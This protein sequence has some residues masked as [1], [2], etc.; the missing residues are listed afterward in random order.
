MPKRTVDYNFTQKVEEQIFSCVIA[1]I[2]IDTVNIAYE[3]N[4]IIEGVLV[5]RYQIPGIDGQLVAV[6]V[7]MTEEKGK[8]HC[9]VALQSEF[10]YQCLVL[11]CVLTIF[12]LI[13]PPKIK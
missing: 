9:Y 8:D 13:K 6:V 2:V 3:K 1:D 4:L 5:R 7:C 11:N 12:G 10:D